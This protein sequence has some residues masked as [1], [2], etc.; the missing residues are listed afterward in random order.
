M[1]L[2]CLHPAPA[3]HTIQAPF[4]EE[5]A[6]L[7]FYLWAGYRFRPAADNSD[8][9]SVPTDDDVAGVIAGELFCRYPGRCKWHWRAIS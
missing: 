6:T 4:C 8:Y 7:I 5:T 3:A 2:Q 9:L 1:L